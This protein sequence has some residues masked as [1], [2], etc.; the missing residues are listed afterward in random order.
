MKRLMFFLMAIV[1]AIQGW[2]QCTTCPT[3]SYGSINMS[4][5]PCDGTTVSQATFTY[6]NEYSDVSGITLGNVYFFQT[7]QSNKY[8]AL[9]TTGGTLLAHGMQPLMWVATETS[10]RFASYDASNCGYYGG[11]SSWARQVTCL[12][13]SCTPPIVSYTNLVVGGNV[14]VVWTELGTATEWELEYK[15]STES[16]ATDAIVITGIT[17][18]FYNLSGLDPNVTYNVRVRSVCNSGYSDPPVEGTDVSYWM[19]TNITTY[20][21]CP[22]IYGFA[23]G[24]IDDQSISVSWTEIGEDVEIV[25]GDPATFD[26]ATDTWDNLIYVTSGST[27]PYVINGLTA[28]TSYKV[29]VRNACGGAWSNVATV[30]TFP[31]MTYGTNEWNGYVFSSGTTAGT[32]ATF[33]NFLG[34]VT[35]PNNNGFV[36]TSS[37]AWTGTTSNWVGTAPSDGFAVRYMCETTL[38]C[39]YYKFTLNGS[40]LTDNIDDQ[41]R[42]S[43]DG[44]LTWVTGNDLWGSA[45]MTYQ[46]ADSIY[47]AAGTY[48]MIVDF[49]E[50]SGDAKIKF[51][52]TP[53]AAPFSTSNLMA[54][55]V[56]IDFPTNNPDWTTWAVMVSTTPVSPLNQT[57]TGDV[58]NTITTDNPYSV[59]GLLSE[60]T[61]YIYA[62]P[63]N[64]CDNDTLWRSKTITTLI[65]CPAP[66]ALAVPTATITTT[67]AVLNWTDSPMAQEYVVEWKAANVAWNDPSVQSVVV[68]QGT[69]TY[70]LTGLT[71]S[72][73]YNAR[74]RSVCDPGVDSSSWATI[75]FVSACGSVTNFP[76][77]EGF[78]S[79]F[80]CWTQAGNASYQTISGS[81]SSPSASPHS[82]SSML[83]YNNWSYSS[84][85]W[86]TLASPEFDF[87][88]PMR[89]S[90]WLYRYNDGS[91]PNDRVYI[92]I[93]STPSETGATLLAEINPDTTASNWYK[94]EILLNDDNN[95]PFLGSQYI[96]IKGYSGFGYSVYVDDITIDEQPTCPDMYGV[97]ISG[98]DD[99]SIAVSWTDMGEDV[100][101]VYGDPATFNLATDTWDNSVIVPTGSTLPY[102]ITGLTA[103]TSYSFALRHACSGNNGTWSSVATVST[104][105]VMT[106]GIDEWNGYVYNLN[107]NPYQPGNYLGIVTEPAVFTRQVSSGVWTGATENWVTTAPSDNF[108]VRYLMTTDFDCGTYKFNLNNVDD[109]ARLSLDGGQT[110]LI[111]RPNWGT[112]ID[113]GSYNATTYLTAGTYNIVLDFYEVGG[114]AGLNFS[115]D[116]VPM[117][118][119]TSNVTPH[120][121][122]VEFPSGS[123]SAWALKVSSTSLTDPENQTGDIEDLIVTSNPYTVLG[124]GDNTTYYVYAHPDGGSC[125]SDNMWGA[126][127]FTTLCDSVPTL[128]GTGGVQWSENFS[129]SSIPCW[130]LN[131]SFTF[132]NYN[133]SIQLRF[134]GSG[135]HTAML[136]LFVDDV[137]QLRLRF[138]LT[139]ESTTYS[140]TFAVGYYD[141]TN[142]FVPVFPI[143]M[144]AGTQQS[145]EYLL[146]DFPAG[147]HNI[148]LRQVA[149]PSGYWYWLDNVIVDEIPSCLDV[150]GVAI[151]PVDEQSIAVS[152]TEMGEDVE[153]VYGDP[154]TFDLA[155]NTWDNSVIVPTGSTL[156]YVITGLTTETSYSF[157]LR[158]ACSGGN[159]GNWSS[160]TTIS[161]FPVMTY[162]TDEW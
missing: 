152:W 61:Y 38:D 5:N 123:G 95:D 63:V 87:T 99:E 151:T 111:Q 139:R 103:E 118:I 98:V 156:P 49:Y 32:Y 136:P 107:T 86:A 149:A 88:D 27:L 20:P 109:N 21:L 54:N 40:S 62:H 122:D 101:I 83:K 43:I 140:G 31:V 102:V 24:G 3:Y 141:A 77:T 51:A 19:T 135:S 58:E 106:Y 52:Y 105:P 145:F 158:H 127:S 130:T 33:G 100:E 154:A 143:D 157:A 79:G 121:V 161:T 29:A 76:W 1:F 23:A 116:T 137:N 155:T 57:S 75:N 68:T 12:A 153:I 110:W 35:E 16:W 36:R 67:D 59:T 125:V 72:N 15:L 159:N 96:I 41:A 150:Y 39:G 104:F 80:G 91:Y 7:N 84:G 70:L 2:S 112:G 108:Y 144:P 66:T 4:S 82:G 132:S 45:T 134:N 56:D 42:V 85:T 128:V 78:E 50:N 131:G 146:T 44:G 9:F 120:S 28:Q 97:A 89:L 124:L 160:V 48:N 117:T 147:V 65:S 126:I 34:T 129:T 25:Y 148:A 46:R 8:I 64:A 53:I 22:N 60:H 10:V 114:G 69:G 13:G 119:T 14:D 55:S 74:L 47:I 162:G 92:Y 71:P 115:W 93:N 94:Y 81:S 30:S 26:L 90:F 142:V 73:N 6:D 11:S 138:L 18:T 37:G 113:N 17:D 133:S